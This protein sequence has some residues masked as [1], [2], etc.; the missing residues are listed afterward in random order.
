VKILMPSNTYLLLAPSVEQQ[1]HT[2]LLYKLLGGMIWENFPNWVCYTAGYFHGCTKLASHVWLQ[3]SVFPLNTSNLSMSNSGNRPGRVKTSVLGPVDEWNLLY[4]VRLKD[5]RFYCVHY[6]VISG[7][8]QSSTA[9][10]GITACFIF[11]FHVH[12]TGLWFCKRGDYS[13]SVCIYSYNYKGSMCTMHGSGLLFAF[14]LSPLI[15]AHCIP[16]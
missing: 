13:A 10:P 8:F 14:P 6:G 4:P 9:L 12:L 5:F 3:I 15:H 16:L 1:D 11:T 7:L 2:D